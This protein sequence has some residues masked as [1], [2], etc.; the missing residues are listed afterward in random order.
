MKKLAMVMLIISGLPGIT[1]GAVLT[2][3]HDTAYP[4]H[5]ITMH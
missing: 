3:G 1:L 2:V 4:Y 5:T